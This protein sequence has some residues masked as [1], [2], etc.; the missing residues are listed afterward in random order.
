MLRIIDV[1][2]EGGPLGAR[3]PKIEKLPT[4]LLSIAEVSTTT[5]VFPRINKFWIWLCSKGSSRLVWWRNRERYE[6][7]N[8]AVRNCFLEACSFHMT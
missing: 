4:S 7:F 5:S 2:T 6:Y 3:A 8:L 1:G